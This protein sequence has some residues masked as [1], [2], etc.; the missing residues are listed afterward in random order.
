MIAALAWVPPNC[1]AATPRKQEM[2]EEEL[3]M[4][5]EYGEDEKGMREAMEIEM[6]GATETLP[7]A[8]MSSMASTLEALE[9]GDDDEMS[10]QEDYTIKSTDAVLVAAKSEQDF[11]CLEVHI[12]ETTTGNFYVHHDI[13]MPAFPLCVEWLDCPCK[14]PA[15]G[16]AGLPT[17]SYIAVGTFKPQIEIWDLNV[18][19]AIEPVAI[20]GGPIKAQRYDPNPTTL[21]K[22]SHTNAVMSVS[23]N[24]NMRNLVASGSADGT[25]KIW[26]LTTQACRLTLKHHRGKV[27][28][29]AWHTSEATILASG[30][31]DRSCVVVD[32]RTHS[33]GLK[34]K[35]ASDIECFSWDPHNRPLFTAGCDDGSVITYDM[36][37]PRQPVMRWNA[38]QEAVSSLSYSDSIPG[39]LATASTDATVS[40]FNTRR[41]DPDR[42]A[43]P[44]RVVS[45]DM[46]AGGLFATQFAPGRPF[47]LAAGGAEGAVAIWETD[48][49]EAVAKEFRGAKT[50][51][52][53]LPPAAGLSSAAAASATASSAAFSASASASASA[54][55]DLLGSGS[56]EAANSKRRK[57][58][59]KGKGRGKK[60]KKK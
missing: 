39:L 22:D 53:T 29:A 24:T 48:E 23:W 45:K 59:K 52:P 32:V 47:L 36:R 14:E 12:Y 34:F 19:D 13:T 54:L 40:L 31:F 3:R 51:A 18:M 27:Q 44:Y 6:G 38:H 9:H 60:K 49:S 4:L 11:S 21:C 16:A 5:K 58:K 10:D 26:D 30:S 17:G 8:G 20:L 56:L 37:N 42:E 46:R 50:T 57:K 43:T 15:K 35:L 55:T 2:T 33:K 25:A 41:R 1:M 7:M 28:T